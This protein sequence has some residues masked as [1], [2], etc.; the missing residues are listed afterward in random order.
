MKWMLC[1][2]GQSICLFLEHHFSCQ[3]Q[4]LLTDLH[5]WSGVSHVYWL[6]GGTCGVQLRLVVVV[7]AVSFL[8]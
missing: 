2:D 4:L 8:E 7:A 1:V 5:L 3:E 6:F